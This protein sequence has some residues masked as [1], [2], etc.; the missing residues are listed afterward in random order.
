MHFNIAAHLCK[1]GFICQRACMLFQ[2]RS[3]HREIGCAGF[4]YAGQRFKKR[5][6]TGNI[7]GRIGR[8]FVKETHQS[9]KQPVCF[10]RFNKI[11]L[12]DGLHQHADIRFPV[13]RGSR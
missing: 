6:K 5:R 3:K 4:L 9:D 8:V 2:H 1:H 11:L 7:A 13:L 10:I 12:A